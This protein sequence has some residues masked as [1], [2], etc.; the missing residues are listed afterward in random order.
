[1][2][3]YNNFSYKPDYGFELYKDDKLLDKQP[4]VIGAVCF[5]KVFGLLDRY[6]N[7]TIFKG[8][9]TLKCRK[10][11][12]ECSGNYCV[13]SKE[14]I[15]KVVNV[16]RKNFDIQVTFKETN[17][18]FEFMFTVIGKSIKHKFILTFSRVFF[19]YPYNEF[20]QEVFR[21]KELGKLDNINITN[22]NF[23]TLYH[24]VQMS[25]DSWGGGHSLFNCPQTTITYKTL[26]EK[27]EA[28]YRRVQEIYPGNYDYYGNIHNRK[29]TSFDWDNNFA[30]RVKRYSNNF[31]I[32][33]KLKQ[34]EHKENIR[35]RKLA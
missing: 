32:L 22:V 3:N 23:L 9:Y 18:N 33:K 28:G 15:I 13:L 8:I 6:N 16:I 4:W 7:H 10:N 5:S 34:N 29:S 21:L 14:N 1:M 25:Y 24:L 35:R 20:A 27:F 12:V 30:S 19:E 31:Q 2:R 11:F 17:D 26:L